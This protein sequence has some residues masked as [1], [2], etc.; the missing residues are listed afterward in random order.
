MPATFFVIDISSIKV[1]LWAM[2][3][4]ARDIDAHE[5]DTYT[6]TGTDLELQVE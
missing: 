5:W 1:L 4:T 6:H 3:G 2:N